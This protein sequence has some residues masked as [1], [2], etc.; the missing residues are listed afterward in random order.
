MAHPSYPLRTTRLLLRPVTLDD[1]DDVHAWQRRPDVVRWMRGA[2]PRTREASRASVA[3]MAGETALRAEGDCLTLAAVA[4]T[5]VVGAVELV[6]RSQADRTAEL[7]Y[8]FHPDHGGRGLATEATTAVLDWGFGEFGLH[9]VIARCH[10]GNEASAR[11][12]SRLG[13]RRE[14]RHVRSYRFRGEWADQLVFAVLA[15]EWRAGRDALV[16]SSG[17]S[18][19]R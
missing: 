11:L 18:P 9:R 7:G 1:L 10:A 6:W 5:R 2:E 13:M 17:A 3:A 14:A 19:R 12:A 15:E 16:D 4:G 8:V